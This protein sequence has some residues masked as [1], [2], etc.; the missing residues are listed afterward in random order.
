MS[1]SSVRVLAVS[2]RGSVRPRNED[3]VG[4]G[5]R[6][7]SVSGSSTDL[8]ESVLPLSNEPL[9]L[10][11]CDGMGGHDG[12]EL[13]S[14]L[15]IEEL[16]ARLR[17]A[18]DAAGIVAAIR[19]VNV[20]IVRRGG[21]SG[22]VRMGTTVAGLSVGLRR[23]FWFNVGD[24]RIYRYRNGFL[25]QLSTD[26]VGRDGG[27][28]QSLGGTTDVVEVDPHLGEEPNTSGWSYLLCSDG[29]T[30]VIDLDEMEQSMKLEPRK[31]VAALFDRAMNVGAPDNISVLLVA[32]LPS[33][34]TDVPEAT[35]V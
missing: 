24:S 16:T 6:Q 29:I 25:R 27:L 35:R 8:F 10:L 21:D 3:R 17:E 34:V 18:H 31:A 33:D 22:Q 9:P 15:A 4:I 20:L 2:H 19:A 23:S 32:M 30:K 5:E 26:D 1:V 11:V 28:T 13:A 7:V 14:G 12:G